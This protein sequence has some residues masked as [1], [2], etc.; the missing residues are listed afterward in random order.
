MRE[1]AHRYFC[2]GSGACWLVGTAHQAPKAESYP[3]TEPLNRNKFTKNLRQ[4]SNIKTEIKTN[5]IKQFR[6]YTNNA[7]HYQ[8]DKEYLQREENYISVIRTGFLGHQG[9][10]VN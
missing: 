8:N 9:G 5:R 7:G 2:S 4:A 6:G 10:S 3:C 1:K